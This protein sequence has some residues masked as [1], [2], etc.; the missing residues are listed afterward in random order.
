MA[1]GTL[2][3]ET[4]CTP[5][6]TVKA[7]RDNP[8]QLGTMAPRLTKSVVIALLDGVECAG[9]S[10]ELAPDRE[11]TLLLDRKRLKPAPVG[12][13]CDRKREERDCH[14]RR[15]DEGVPM[16]PVHSAFSCDGPNYL[17]VLV[18]PWVS[19]LGLGLMSLPAPCPEKDAPY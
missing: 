18:S 19:G 8:V 15:R 1:S 7:T 3:I 4:S 5:L 12:P 6:W 2:S 14:Q 16:L 10:D 9:S 11:T 17:V 13:L